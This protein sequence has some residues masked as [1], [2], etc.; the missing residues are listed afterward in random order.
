M[1]AFA[2]R[3]AFLLTLVAPSAWADALKPDQWSGKQMS[4]FVRAFQYLGD[5]SRTCKTSG[6]TPTQAPL[7]VSTMKCEV[8]REG[9]KPT[10]RVRTIRFEAEG[11]TWQGLP[12]AVI[13]Y[14]QTSSITEGMVYHA[15]ITYTFS[16]PYSVL[17]RP[18]LAKWRREQMQPEQNP[19]G[20]G[21][22]TTRDAITQS[23]RQSGKQSMFVSEF[24]E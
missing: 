2:G 3:I 21:Y 9:G 11:L 18:L 6:N 17:A 23:V 24:F 14:Q 5:A 7:P 8:Y 10:T 12:I 22:F 16:A 13:E 4:E 15:A 20:G 1:P 19:T